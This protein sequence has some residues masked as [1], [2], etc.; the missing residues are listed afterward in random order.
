MNVNARE[1]VL[2]KADRYKY[3][4][5]SVGGKDRLPDDD[6]GHLIGDNLMV[7]LI[8]IILYHKIVK[9]IGGVEFGTKWRLSRP[10]H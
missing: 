6:G 9:S 2:K 8:L 7:L 5:A 10:M 1:L 4:Q 3:A